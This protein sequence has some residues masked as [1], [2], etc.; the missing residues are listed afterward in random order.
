MWK[1]SRIL[2][3]FKKDIKF[4]SSD[5]YFISIVEGQA[6]LFGRVGE[7]VDQIPVVI[8]SLVTDIS[9][10]KVY[11]SI[12]IIYIFSLVNILSSQ[13]YLSKTARSQF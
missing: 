2:S 11:I 8:L 12:F 13:H 7:F 5:F 3:I 6:L 10:K 4:N 1:H 9:K